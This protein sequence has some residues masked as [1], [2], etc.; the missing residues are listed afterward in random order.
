MREQ[1]VTEGGPGE[2]APADEECPPVKPEENPQGDPQEEEVEFSPK[3]NQGAARGRRDKVIPARVEFRGG[4]GEGG[5][6]E[7]LFRSG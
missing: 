6:R 2:D 7:R 5:V 4:E 1:E 3:P